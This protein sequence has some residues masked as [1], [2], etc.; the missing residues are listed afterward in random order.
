MLFKKISNFIS[1]DK[2]LLFIIFLFSFIINKNYANLG[3]FPIDTFFHFD[4]AF[5]VLNGEYPIKDFWVVSGIFVDYLQAFFFYI[6]GVSWKAYTLHSSFINGILAIV[7]YFVLRNLQLKKI[8]SFLYS[9]FFAVLAYP[10]SATPFVDQHS[11]LLSLLAIYCFILAINKNYFFYWILTPIFLGLAFLSKQVPSAY[12]I[13]S[14]TFIII[15]YAIKKKDLNPIK[16]SFVGSLIF[17]FI[18]F[19]VGSIQGISLSEFLKQYIIYPQNIANSRLYNLNFSFNAIVGQYKFIYL[20]FFPFIY[21]NIKNLIFNKDYLKEKNFYI[22]LAISFYFFGLIFHQIL[23]KNQI[24]I[25]YLCP[26]IFAF[27]KIFLK[28]EV[29]KYKNFIFL[30]ILIVSFS[31]TLKYHL[32]FNEGRKFHELNQVNFDLSRDAYK[33]DKKLAGLKWITPNYKNNPQKEIDFLSETLKVIKNDK[34]EKMVLTN[35]LFFSA[36]LN[37]NLHAPSRSQTLEGLSFPVKNNEYYL[38]DKNFFL[39]I[40]KSNK[41]QVIY[42]ISSDYEV[43]DRFVYDYL[44]KAC[45]IE[46]T[47]N[48]QF[49]KFEINKC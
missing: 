31:V 32:R 33:L 18:I 26:L 7:T 29:Y 17:I 16:Y 2:F 41:I 3:V 4:S 27:L 15:F 19:L 9:L 47:F 10:V 25:Y 14:L 49:K 46:H 34:R 8:Y 11:S 5:R 36:I 37:E 1:N 42:I 45:V 24:F 23:T 22:F 48:K 43:E 30:F 20:G 21:L 39:K 13:I 44:D 12:I 28:N 40:K 6:F 38:K 35:Y